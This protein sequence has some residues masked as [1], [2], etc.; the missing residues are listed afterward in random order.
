MQLGSDGW[1]EEKL[2]EAITGINE[3]SI[4]DSNPAT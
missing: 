2:L 4:A 3:I 1:D